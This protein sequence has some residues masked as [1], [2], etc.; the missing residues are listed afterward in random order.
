[1]VV[2][3]FAGGGA[4]CLLLGKQL[5]SCQRLHLALPK[6]CSQKLFHHEPWLCRGSLPDRGSDQS[7]H[8]PGPN[9]PASSGDRNVQCAGRGFLGLSGTGLQSSNPLGG[10]SFSFLE[11]A[12]VL[13]VGFEPTKLP[14][15]R[16]PCRRL[17]KSATFPLNTAQLVPEISL[18]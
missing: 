1:M 15:S 5:P 4:I 11:L 12:L 18:A 7:Q 9:T 17:L 13:K 8:C 16:W 3:T 14:L 10:V 6:P 2:D